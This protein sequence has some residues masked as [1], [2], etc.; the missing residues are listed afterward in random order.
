MNPE[1]IS[2]VMI[3]LI[4]VVWFGG[5]LH[6]HPAH[7]VPQ[8][9]LDALTTELTAIISS[10]AAIASVWPDEDMS[11]VEV[12]TATGWSIVF[13][14]SM[15]KIARIEGVALPGGRRY[16]YVAIPQDIDRTA[17]AS[18]VWARMAELEAMP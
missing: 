16:G 18:A 4:L 11:T 8:D 10:P 2:A 7:P 13:M 3:I 12:E 15:G 17:L 9:T 5:Y 1:L 14:C 6:G